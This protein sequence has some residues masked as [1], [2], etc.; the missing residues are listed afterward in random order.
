MGGLLPVQRA[1]RQ[2]QENL[3][4]RMEA[5]LPLD[6]SITC[7]WSRCVSSSTEDQYRGT[8]LL[9]VVYKLLSTIIN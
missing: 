3:S 4:R 1:I 2:V 6:T 7:I 5:I 8:A 9:E